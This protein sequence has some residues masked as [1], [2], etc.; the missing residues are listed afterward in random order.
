VAAI[1]PAAARRKLP[2][3][4]L[5]VTEELA[6]LNRMDLIRSML[7]CVDDVDLYSRWRFSNTAKRTA[8]S[9]ELFLDT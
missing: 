5:G 4:K 1:R 2:V 9:D 6:Q 8:L 7:V 3:A